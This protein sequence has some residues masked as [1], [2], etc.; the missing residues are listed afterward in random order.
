MDVILLEKIENLGGIGDMV[1]VKA[2]YGRNYLLPTGKAKLATKANMAEFEAMRA[3]LEQRA[4]K[5]LA[6]AKARAEKLDGLRVARPGG[7]RT[8]GAP[9]H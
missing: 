4:A 6:A 1:S 7:T 5:E 8:R 9:R 3:E 2:G